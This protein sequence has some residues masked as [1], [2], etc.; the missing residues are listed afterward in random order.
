MAYLRETATVVAVEPQGEACLLRLASPALAAA[1]RPFQFLLVRVPGGG[2][3]LRRPFSVFDARGEEVEVLIRPVGEGTARL[4]A[5]AVGEKLD[6]L[7]PLGQTFSPPAEALYV[8]GGVGVAG[9]F[10]AV[11]EE[12][13][14]GRQPELLFGAATEAALYGR[15]RLETLGVE[16]TYVT[17]DG[18]CGERG[19]ATEHLPGAATGQE[20][21]MSAAMAE[22]LPPY[23][24]AVVACG[25][26]PM[27]QALFRSLGE[28][29]RLYVVMEERMACGVGA[30]RGC[31]V[32]AREPEGGYLAVCQEGPVIEASRLDWLR[33][34]EEV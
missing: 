24:R 32:P 31:A 19:L 16:A 7:G 20:K 17:E 14:A 22:T 13:R 30:C 1:V 12:V 18:S 3:A 23:A 5:V 34:A 2:F 28:E 6:L 11:A 25:P 21:L 8:A 10:F 4:G 33:L 26:R 27:Y 15:G 9:L 29:A